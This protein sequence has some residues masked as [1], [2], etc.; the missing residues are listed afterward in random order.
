MCLLNLL[1]YTVLHSRSFTLSREINFQQFEKLLKEVAPKYKKDKKLAT[2]DEA[3]ADMKKE[4]VAHL[5]A[6]H[7]PRVCDKH[8]SALLP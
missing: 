2:D 4:I 3:L 1:A 7:G 8:N 6:G 5:S